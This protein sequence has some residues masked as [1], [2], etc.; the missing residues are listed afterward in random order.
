MLIPH[1]I[2]RPATHPHPVTALEA[3]PTGK[4]TK[5]A[6]GGTILA[7][8]TEG[9]DLY[10]WGQPPRTEP[11]RA[12]LPHADPDPESFSGHQNEN[13]SRREAETRFFATLTGD[14]TPVDVNNWQDIADIAIGERHLLALTTEGQVFAIGDNTNGQ[15][16][17]PEV[18]HSTDVW[19]KVNIDI[20]ERAVIMGV[21][22]GPR[23]SF[24]I[25]RRN[26]NT[27]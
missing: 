3:L 18:K 7:A 27:G 24:V 26:S 8:L 5:I 20:D 10:A 1:Y 17:L 12:P 13:N 2:S 15:L 22:A 11:F 25:V 16:G 9:Q 4:I 14:P 6:A 21:V 23:N 19:M